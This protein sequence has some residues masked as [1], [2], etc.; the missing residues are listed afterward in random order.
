[1]TSIEEPQGDIPSEPQGTT[2][3]AQPKPGDDA[4]SWK[5][6]ATKWQKRAK[7]NNEQ[8]VELKQQVERLTP[9]ETKLAETTTELQEVQA[10]ATRYRIA[11]EAGLSPD[12]ATRLV[13]GTEE[14]LRA[15][16]E[17]LQA[18]V[19]SKPAG[20]VNAAQAS[21]PN[22]KPVQPSDLNALLRAAA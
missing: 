11:L 3:E 20:A 2:A 18:L 10:S 9:V 14:E 4:A 1:M 5:E 6:T 8:L 17:T 13:G 12:L 15:D 19:K 21:G 7:A 22:T 16:A